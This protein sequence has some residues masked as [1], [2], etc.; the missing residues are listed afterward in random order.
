MFFKQNFR[1]I[2]DNS[3]FYPLN[4]YIYYICI[5]KWYRIDWRD[6]IVLAHLGKMM[7]D[8]WTS[9]RCFSQKT[10]IHARV[11]EEDNCLHLLLVCHSY[12]NNGITI[13]WIL[14]PLKI[15]V[16]SNS[17]WYEELM[18]KYSV[19]CKNIPRNPECLSFIINFKGLHLHLAL[20]A[21]KNA[22]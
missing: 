22:F 4:N 1:F 11:A 20:Q 16:F 10:A 18:P 21:Y 14:I 15:L 13:I 3:I 5:K 9:V 8:F 19:S 12:W 2:V 17:L 6:K 7:Q